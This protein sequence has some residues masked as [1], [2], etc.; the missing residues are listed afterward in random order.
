MDRLERPGGETCHLNVKYMKRLT[1]TSPIDIMITTSGLIFTPG[2]SSSKNRS[3]P[4][5]AAGMGA[6]L[7]RRF[8]RAVDIPNQPILRWSRPIKVWFGETERREERYVVDILAIHGWAFF[9]N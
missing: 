7:L 8:S 3:N 1:A 9:L 4:A 2:V 5:L 6:S